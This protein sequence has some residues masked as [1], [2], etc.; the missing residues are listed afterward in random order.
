M[1]TPQNRLAVIAIAFALAN[2][3]AQPASGALRL[4]DQ[5]SPGI[6]ELV[7]CSFDQTADKIWVYT[8]FGADLSSYSRAGTSLT[9]VSRPGEAANDVDIEFAPEELT[10]GSKTIPAGTLL[11]INGETGATDIYAVNKA[12][13]A[14]I[15][16]L[17][18]S[19]GVSHVVGGAYHPGRKTFFLVQ[20]RVPG[21]TDG[22][23][24]AEVS[25]T[26]GNVLNTF[27]LSAD[28]FEVNF[29]DIEVSALTGNLL[30]VS[31]VESR[32][33]ELRPTGKFVKYLPLPAGVSGLSGIGLDDLAG[34]A[35]V[36]STSG[37]VFHLG[38]LPPSAV[39]GN[40]STRLRVE[41][42][43]DVLIGGFIVTGTQPKK[44]IVRAIGPSLTVAGKLPNPTLEL[45]RGQTLLESNDDWVNS[46]KKQAIINSTVP[47]TNDLESA[48]VR[49]LPANG[50]SYTAV[51]RG[52]G[53]GTG[54]GLV[55]VYDLDRTVD[56]QLANISSRGLVQAGD[57]VM[58]GGFIISGVGS[59]KVIVR[60]IGPS[61]SVPGKLA[62]PTLELFNRDGVRIAS[63]DN[64]RSN[65]EAAIIASTVPPTDN[66]EAAIV[67]TLPPTPHTAIVS[68][69]G[70]ATGVAL[71]EVYA[72]E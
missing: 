67:A 31:S 23:R 37:T 27:Q 24:I 2:S 18:T 32:V 72:L 49:T 43:D 65:Q 7:S 35:W 9:N 57:N 70:G 11:F 5:F 22:N 71:V 42:G 66:L 10:L 1:K 40:I 50:T 15:A 29:G 13:G 36:T 63:N 25:A 6:G 61:L 38:G 14:V 4:I 48:I 58:I 41:I 16:T 28:V 51:V 47:P 17:T 30:V 55:E 12:T 44:V 3:A 62:D 59:K 56:S 20:D 68:G 69:K 34:E 52:A 39:L 64:W 53:G 54:I 26:T 33:L 60:A 21:G 46:A 45:Y 19:F 8:S